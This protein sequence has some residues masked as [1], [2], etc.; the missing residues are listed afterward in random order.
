M[1]ASRL[2][3]LYKKYLLPYLSGFRYKGHLI[4]SEPIEYLLRGFWF[5][6]SAFS[7]DAF[8]VYVFVQP[9]YVPE[10]GIAFTFGQRLP[11]LRSKK[12]RWWELSETNEEE[13]MKDV[14]QAILQLGLP[15]LEQFKTPA[16]LAQ[17]AGKV[18]GSR[19]NPHIQ[20]AV[21]YSRVLAGETHKALKALDRLH[22][23]LRRTAEYDWEREMDRRVLR[24]RI[25]LA[26][27][28]QEA[29]HLLTEWREYTL[30]NLRLVVE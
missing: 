4:Y 17:K 19:D 10:E 5:E 21:A 8:T 16:D 2:K 11:W 22:R 26:H 7:A 23:Y 9:L 6:S 28:P 25:A 14:Q 27:D 20:E 15:F 12:D 30:K 24:I 1:K 3:P 18:I 29:I 13:V